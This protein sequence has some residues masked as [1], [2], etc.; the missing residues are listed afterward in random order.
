MAQPRRRG[1]AKAEA[2]LPGRKWA[3]VL[4]WLASGAVQE[5]DKPGQ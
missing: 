1:F 5:M 3:L 4:G 2:R